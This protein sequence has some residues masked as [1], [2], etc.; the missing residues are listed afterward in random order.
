MGSKKRKHNQEAGNRSERSTGESKVVMAP[1]SSGTPYALYAA[2]FVIAL[3][4]SY[5]VSNLNPVSTEVVR[6]TEGTAAVPLAQQDELIFSAYAGSQSCQACHEEQFKDWKNSHHGLAEREIVPAMDDEAFNPHRTI[7]HGTQSSEARK[8]GEGTYELVTRSRNDKVEPHALK[9]AIGVSPLL[10]YLVETEGGRFQA[11]EL[12]WDPHK[13]EWFNVYGEEDRVTGEWGHWTGRG[14]N[15]NAMCASCHNTRLQKNY[16]PT[17]DTYHTRMAEMG[18]GCESCHGGMKEHVDWQN[19]YAQAPSRP[20]VDPTLKKHQF[21]RDQM[22]D[23]CGPCHA[24]R[25]ELTGDYV[26]GEDFFDHYSLVIPDETDIFYPDGQVRDED[27]EFTSFLSSRMHAA[28]VRCF[29]CHNPHSAKLRVPGNLMCMTC[30]GGEQTPE[31]QQWGMPVIPKIDPLSHSH[32]KSETEPGGRCVDCHMPLTTYMQRHP[33]H[34]HG[35]TIPDPLLTKQFGIPNACNRCHEKKDADW[36]LGHVE[37]WY[38]DKMDR[39]YRTRSQWVAMAK[40]N[41]PG[42]HINLINISQNDT[43]FLWRAVATGLMRGYLREPD[44]REEL[45][46]RLTDKHPLVRGT[47]VLALDQMAQREGSREQNALRNLLQD[48]S[49]KVRVDAAWVLRSVVETNT[50][51]GRELFSYFAATAD[52]PAGMMQQGVFHYDRQ[53]YATAAAFFRRA[54]LWDTNSAAPHHELAVTLSQQQRSQEAVE[55]LRIATKI[56][57]EQ[58]EFRYKLALGLHELGDVRGATKE[59]EETVKIDPRHSSALYNLGL[60]YDQLNRPGEALSTLLKAQRADNLS[61]R[62][63]YARATILMKLKRNAEAREAVRLALRLDSNYTP[64]R[65]LYQQLGGAN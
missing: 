25:S 3:A 47:A 28:G 36:A 16:D 13:K 22:R 57:P 60:A 4:I 33:R 31:A 5:F 43:N 1:K 24:R 48:P 37:T 10:Q 8:K 11:A 12:A 32:H 42:S 18:V 55:E 65:R 7:K 15:W 6:S 51:A 9:R 29:D 41:A 61:P 27:Y 54:S 49:R 44:V 59:L 45:L 62:I 52:Q 53:D 19:E 56:A 38:G 23:S 2:L 46:K 64:A 14:M 40:T 21:N 35:F 34:D 30:H 39:P 58:A 20:A 26:P 17:T 50:V 63:P